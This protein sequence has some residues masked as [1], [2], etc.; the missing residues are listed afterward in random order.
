MNIHLLL[1]QS[2]SET[3]SVQKHVHMKQQSLYYR[4]YIRHHKNQYHLFQLLCDSI[5]DENILGFDIEDEIQISVNDIRLEIDNFIKKH[6]AALEEI[7]TS[8]AEWEKES[9][10]EIV[11]ERFMELLDDS[12]VALNDGKQSDKVYKQMHI[13]VNYILYN[14]LKL[15][16]Q[17]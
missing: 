4:A 13:E 16:W 8:I 2:L 14:I 9:R 1:V 11:T 5:L 6:S 12:L 3:C 7:E 15:L 17:F 10:S